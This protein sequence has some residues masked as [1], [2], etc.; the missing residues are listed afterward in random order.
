MEIADLDSERLEMF[1]LPYQKKVFL[2]E[3]R[4][5]SKLQPLVPT[6]ELRKPTG[7]LAD[8]AIGSLNKISG[9][10]SLKRHEIL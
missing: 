8:E 3:A 5:G 4:G 7:A 6:I 2:N 1:F 9:L 10:Y